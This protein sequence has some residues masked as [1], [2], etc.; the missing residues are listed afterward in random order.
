MQI[1]TWNIQWC[2]GLDGVADPARTVQHALSLGDIDVLCLQEVAVGH[3]GLAGAPGDQVAQIQALL[4]AQNP[5]WQVFFGPTTDGFT[6]DGTRRAFGN[7]IATRLPVCEVAHHRLPWPAEAGVVSMPRGCSVVT[8]QDPQL[9]LV[10]V[11]TTHLE[12]HSAAQ[13]LAQA[14]ALRGLH[15]EALALCTAT[16]AQAGAATPYATPVHT[17]YAVLCGDFNMPASEAGYAWLTSAA[18]GAEGG[19]AADAWHDAWNL[20]W[21]GQLQP[22]TFCVADRTW[23]PEPVACDFVFTSDSLRTAVRSCS[24][25]GDTRV[26]DH[27]PVL[28]T[29][30]GSTVA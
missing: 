27:Q 4:Q 28:L 3:T 11:L 18:D 21:P 23:G 13:R 12:Y 2:C 14:Q 26:S 7:L 8:V 22:P 10:R 9:G 29:L 15:H 1:L 16:P 5:Q 19:A 20:A 17:P 30:A 24:V 25:D 6:A